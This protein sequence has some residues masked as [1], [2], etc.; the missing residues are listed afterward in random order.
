MPTR[1]FYLKVCRKFAPYQRLLKITLATI[2]L[3]GFTLYS[4]LARVLDA[5]VTVMI[6]GKIWFTLCVL[7]GVIYTCTHWF[8]PDRDH[9]DCSPVESWN[10]L[11]INVVLLVVIFTWLY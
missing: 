10:V 9:I 6:I 2:W 1:N 3:G 5:P 11:V 7:L 4:I 8:N